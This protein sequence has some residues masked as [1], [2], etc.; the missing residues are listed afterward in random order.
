MTD[1]IAQHKALWTPG[2]YELDQTIVVGEQKKFWFFQSTPSQDEIGP[3][4]DDVELVFF[5][6]LDSSSNSEIRNMKILEILH[7]QLGL[8]ARID[9]DGLDYIFTPVDGDEVIVN[10]EEEPG[11]THET[12]LDIHDWSVIVRMMEVPAIDENEAAS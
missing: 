11:T 12:D 7:P 3:L 4:P 6:Q 8:L 2:W 1:T 10:A 9:T 5:N